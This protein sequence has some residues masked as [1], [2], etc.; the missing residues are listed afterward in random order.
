[1]TEF[2]VVFLFGIETVSVDGGLI[3]SQNRY[4]GDIMK[5]AGMTNCK[6]VTM[7]VSV[8][9]SVD[10]S[11]EPFDNPTLYRSI[12]GSLQYLTVTRPNLSYAVNRLC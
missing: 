2:L 4:M 5:R 9:S 8:T 6:S 3:L 1:M 12:A 10:F 11:N 7:L